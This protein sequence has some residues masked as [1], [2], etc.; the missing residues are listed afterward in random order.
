MILKFFIITSSGKK[1][2]WDCVSIS[3]KETL[4]SLSEQRLQ[5]KCFTSIK[6][7]MDAPYLSDI[8]N[9]FDFMGF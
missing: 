6:Y 1:S 9:S 2:R 5:K 8:S 4:L 3:F 7:M